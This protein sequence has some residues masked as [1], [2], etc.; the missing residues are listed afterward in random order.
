MKRIIAL[1]VLIIFLV[2]LIGPFNKLLPESKNP[3]ENVPL[4]KVKSEE[5]VIIN[6]VKEALPSVITVSIKKTTTTQDSI[7]INPFNP[8][9]PFEVR[10]GESQTIEQSIGSGFIVNRD[11]LIVTNRHVVADTDASY[12]IITNDG[13]IYPADKIFRDPLN[14]LAI[15]KIKA[16]GLTPLKLANSNSL[17]LGQIAIAIGTPLGEFQ[18]T[19]TTGIVSGLGRG[20]TAGSPIQGYVEKLDNVIQTDAAINPGNSGGPL[21]NSSA[22]VIGINTAVSQQGQNIGFAIPANV[23]AELLDN[24]QKS[25]GKIS[26]PYLGVRYKVIDEET[27]ILNDLP[28]GAYIIEVV[29]GSNAQEAGLLRGDVITKIDGQQVTSENDITKIL[30][31]KNVGDKLELELYRGGKKT[32]ISITLGEFSS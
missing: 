28:E 5:S 15:I 14:D 25:G 9:S 3:P 19:I 6:A 32:S 27:A 26:R 11:G 17:E 2:L 16:I 10:P 20:I 29:E 18:N 22:Q 23:I 31:T 30:K 1:S 24:Y 4:V 13:K 7:Q 12:K 8:Y 21:L